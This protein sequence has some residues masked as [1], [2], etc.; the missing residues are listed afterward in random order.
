MSLG[1]GKNFLRL[2]NEKPTL[3]TLSGCYLCHYKLRA[4]R[5]SKEIDWDIPRDYY[6]HLLSAPPHNTHARKKKKKKKF[7]NSLDKRTVNK[8]F[9]TSQT[10]MYFY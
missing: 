1:Y 10:Y 3:S 9:D 6:R 7:Q 4:L 8:A 2:T 5:V